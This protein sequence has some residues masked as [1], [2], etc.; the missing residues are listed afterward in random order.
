MCGRFVDPDMRGAGLDTSWLKINPTPRRFSVKPAFRAVRQ[1]P[2]S[3]TDE[4]P[5][6][7]EPLDGPPPLLL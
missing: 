4:G 6:L 7:I 3:S 5:E 1:R 2:F